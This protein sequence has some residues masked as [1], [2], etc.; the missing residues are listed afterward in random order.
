MS[1][2]LIRRTADLRHRISLDLSLQT[3]ISWS[4]LQRLDSVLPVAPSFVRLTAALC[5]LQHLL[6]NSLGI[7]IRVYGTSIRSKSVFPLISDSSCAFTREFIKYSEDL[8][9]LELWEVES[10]PRATGVPRAIIVLDLF[11]RPFKFTG[12]ASLV[13]HGEFNNCSTSTHSVSQHHSFTHP[14]LHCH[15]NHCSLYLPTL[16]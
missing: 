13:T 6:W 16:L 3:D 9:L 2:T 7:E 12:A 15:S 10:Q 4:D 8:L 14:S 1:E 11:S 5:A